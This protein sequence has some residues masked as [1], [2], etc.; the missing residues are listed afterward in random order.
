MSSHGHRPAWLDRDGRGLRLG[1][2]QRD[3]GEPGIPSIG[4]RISD[5]ALTYARAHHAWPTIHYNKAD[6]N[7][8]LELSDNAV[9]VVVCCET[10][11]HVSNQNGLVAEFHR[12]L[13]AGGLLILSTQ[14][15]WVF[16]W[17]DGYRNPYHLHELSRAE[18]RQMLRLHFVIEGVYGQSRWQ[19]SQLHAVLKT[20]R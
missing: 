17:L 7:R 20:R 9:D 14:D 16:S 4:L 8:P 1:L 3:A 5:H 19:G 6:L 13:K 12:V 11:E 18:L 15:R 2:R 10:L